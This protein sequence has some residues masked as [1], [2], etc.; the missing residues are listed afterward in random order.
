MGQQQYLKEKKAKIFLGISRNVWRHQ[1]K[2]VKTQESQAH[3]IKREHTEII[4]KLRR[5]KTKRKT[6]KAVRDK[7]S[8]E[9]AARLTADFSIATME[10]RRQ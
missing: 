3:S 9:V 6:L 10:Y 1:P 7:R 5:P 8:S 4:M 2:D